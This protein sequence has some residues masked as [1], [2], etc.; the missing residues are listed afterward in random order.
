MGS[1]D[2]E[3]FGEYERKTSEKINLKYSSYSNSKLEQKKG[4][5]FTGKKVAPRGKEAMLDSLQDG[6]PARQRGPGGASY[7]LTLPAR[8]AQRRAA[9]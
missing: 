6:E 5:K 9:N 1:S 7:L 8:H 4:K 2:R 3:K